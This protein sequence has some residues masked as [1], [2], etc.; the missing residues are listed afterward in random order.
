MTDF[1]LP[2][3]LAEYFA[4][5]DRNDW[6]ALA[7]CFNPRA[8]MIDDG[9]A[10]YGREEI[11]GSHEKTADTWTYTSALVAADP[12]GPQSFHALVHVEGN[13]PGGVVDLHYRFALLAE[14]IVH[15]TIE[16]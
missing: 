11:R 10:Y 1:T 3:P 5:A 15:L 13:F 9:Q 4:A 7:A 2:T 8:S 14:Q 12:T 16:P 6:S